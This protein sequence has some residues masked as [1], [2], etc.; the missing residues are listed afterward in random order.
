[1]LV[2]EGNQIYHLKQLIDPKTGQVRNAVNNLPSVQPIYQ[3]EMGNIIS[4]D[5][6]ASFGIN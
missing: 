1:V 2:I 5:V 3:D 4:N 6:K